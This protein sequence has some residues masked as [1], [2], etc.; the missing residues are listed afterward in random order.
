MRDGKPEKP[1]IRLARGSRK[2]LPRKLATILC[3][4]LVLIQVAGASGCS[5]LPNARPFEGTV[6]NCAMV[7]GGDYDD[8]YQKIPEFE[9]KTG[10][11]VN[12]TFKSN[13]FEL[14]RQLKM[15]FAAQ[16]DSYD[17]IWNHTSFFTQYIK[18]LEPL[19]SYF[20]DEELRDFLPGLLD[21]CRREGQLWMIPRH[22][23][24]SALYYRTDLFNDPAQQAAFRQK[25]GRALTVPQT[26]DEF[27]EVATFFAKPPELYGTQFAGAE[28]ALTG[29]FYEILFSSGGEFIDASGRAAFNSPI[30]VEAVQMM[31]KL[32]QQDVVPPDLSTYLWDDLA[33]KFAQ[34]QIAL[35]IEW[36]SYTSY[37]RNPTV[38]KIAGNF[39]LARQPA[40]PDGIHGGWAGAHAFSIAKS[41][42]NK[43]AAASLI[44]FLT[45]PENMYDEGEIGFLVV[46][47]S[48]WDRLIQD[49]NAKDDLFKSHEL[50]LA[51]LQL[52][53][54]FR[55]PPL[56]AGY[57]PASNI[58]YPILQ[59][60]IF[61]NADAQQSLD[62]A[63]QAVDQALAKI[64]PSY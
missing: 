62:E 34:G 13:S 40:G 49:A 48:V 57:I 61:E 51:K 47:T 35:Y 33:Q 38:S 59:K 53:E 20:S 37:F 15:D 42:K 4:C 30:G 9:K 43:A 36:H 21:A 1:I 63:A 52:S 41:S 26:W 27:A 16:T 32:Y 55:T 17:V 11:K 25:T 50:E 39:D 18:Y 12:I 64:E 3:I 45:S 46:R 2:R 31:Q 29:R 10:I 58:L 60:I 19:D 54:D 6:L 14:D 22:A 56:I 8:L 28:E 7:S 5:E 44:K 24:I 23:D